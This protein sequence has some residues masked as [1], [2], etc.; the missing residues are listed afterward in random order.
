MKEINSILSNSYLDK[1]KYKKGDPAHEKAYIVNQISKTVPL[2]K[3]YNYVYWLAKVKQF[4]KS[5]GENGHWLIM[6][7]LRTISDYPGDF[8]KGG[9]L[10]NKFKKFSDEYKATQQKNKNTSI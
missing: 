6:N 5:G 3:T 8:N 7:W 10:T 9:I 1:F 4:D 2:T